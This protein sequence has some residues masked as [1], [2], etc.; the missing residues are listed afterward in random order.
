MI[1]KYTRLEREA[2]DLAIKNLNELWRVKGNE[3]TKTNKRARST[4]KKRSR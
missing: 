2:Q 4:N 3:R 1:I